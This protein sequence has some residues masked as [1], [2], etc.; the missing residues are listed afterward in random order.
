MADEPHGG[1]AGEELLFFGQAAAG[2]SHELRNALA[3]VQQ[4]A[5][6]LEDYLAAGRAGRAVDPDRFAAVVA[7]V[8]R[9]ANRGL[10]QADLLHWLGHTVD[11]VDRAPEVGE[12]VRRVVALRQ[13]AARVRRLTLEP[14]VPARPVTAVAGGTFALAAVVDRCL[15]RVMERAA[16]GATLTVTL[17]ED[18]GGVVLSVESD[19]VT[20]SAERGEDDDA[21]AALAAGLGGGATWD[22]A[23]G[24]RVRLVLRIPPAGAGDSA[25]PPTE[26]GTSPTER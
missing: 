7:R 19:G 16:E 2:L 10:D 14:R 1:D 11:R 24:E 3:T 6:L 26:P 12:V 23:P 18:P 13:H 21:L 5:G 20:G 15:V 8:G 17:D 22:D 4:A 9:A 25:G